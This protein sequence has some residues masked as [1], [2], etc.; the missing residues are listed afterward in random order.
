L[1]ALAA[2]AIAVSV[3]VIHLGSALRR[4]EKARETKRQRQQRIATL[5]FLTLL[6]FVTYFTVVP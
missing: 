6:G 4:S 2:A 1:S 3:I 5:L